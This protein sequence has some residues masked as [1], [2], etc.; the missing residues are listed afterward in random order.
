MKRVIILGV[1]NLAAIAPYRP[2]PG[3]LL[4][5]ERM[6]G[7]RIKMYGIAAAAGQP[8]TQLTDAA[9][10]VAVATL[11]VANADGNHGVGFVVVHD[12][13]PAC[14]VLVNWWVHG[15]DLYQRYFRSPLDRPEQLLAITTPAVGCV[16][17][18]AV[19]GHERHAWVRHVLTSPAAADLEAYLAD[20]ADFG[21]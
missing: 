21:L 18:L 4:R 5:I 8:R 12:A 6:D 9:H 16:W 11:P 10:K 20:A 2:R 1:S 15:Y 14:F 17:E 19:T 3:R 13:R 7:W